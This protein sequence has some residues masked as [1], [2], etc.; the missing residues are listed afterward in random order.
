MITTGLIVNYKWKAQIIRWWKKYHVMKFVVNIVVP[1]IVPFVLTFI[2]TDPHF[3]ENRKELLIPVLALWAV[4]IAN[5]IFQFKYW[6]Q[7]RD[8]ALLRWENFASKHAYMGLYRIHKDKK[9]RYSTSSLKEFKSGSIEDKSIPY[10]VFEQVRKI[11]LEFSEVIGD[12]TGIPAVHIS[13]SFIYHY[14]STDI[15]E[16]GWKWV[17][18][19]NSKF[20]GKLNEFISQDNSMYHHMIKNNIPFVFY[21]DKKDAVNKG[22][23]IT[24]QKISYMIIPDQSLHPNLVSTITKKFVVKGF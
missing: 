12:I 13:V 10:D 5:F 11:C 1:F 21:N 7:D 22:I 2:L 14:T 9:T 18:G 8:E 17:I 4:V 23:F 20:N 24:H 3:F 19:R 15:K 6:K 16:Q